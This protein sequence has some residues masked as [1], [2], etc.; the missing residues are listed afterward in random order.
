MRRV[1][2]VLAALL[3][4]ATPTAAS[5][6]T[7]RP[8]VITVGTSIEGGTGLPA[9]QSWPSRLSARCGCDLTDMSLPGGA[10]TKPNEVGDTIRKHVDAAIAVHP[11][12]LII[13]GPVNDLVLM[14]DVTPLRQAVYEAVG[15]AQT[16]GIRVLVM[17]IFPFTDGGAF[18][19]GWWPSLEPRRVTY[20]QWASQMYGDR[21]IDESSLLKETT[22]TRGDARWFRDGLHPTRI[23]AALLAEAFPV[24]K[25]EA[26]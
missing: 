23:G 22:T 17:G 1:A 11:D 8:T 9:G 7:D 16:A 10:Y 19:T 12:V 21:Y 26:S 18:P 5:A 6:S 15:A 20:N 25:L 3:V 14:S 24:E 4:A 2:L 13:G